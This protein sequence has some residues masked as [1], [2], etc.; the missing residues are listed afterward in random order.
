MLILDNKKYSNV[1]GDTCNKKRFKS[2]LCTGKCNQ[3]GELKA[4][5][6]NV[7]T[8]ATA[9][10]EITEK[11]SQLNVDILSTMKAK[12]IQPQSYLD[13]IKNQ[14][15]QISALLAQLTKSSNGGVSG[16]HRD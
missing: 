1:D 2:S 3:G 15:K 7:A 10:K 5:L 6:N 4:H 11:M 8:A 13:Q 12:D 14:R 9:E 16:R